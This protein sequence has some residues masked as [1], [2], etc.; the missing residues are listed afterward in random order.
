RYL[1][2]LQFKS[3]SEQEQVFDTTVASPDGEVLFK[4]TDVVFR[5]V[6][7]EQIK[8]AMES[9]MAEDDQKMYEAARHTEHRAS[10]QC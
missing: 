7:P 3:F 9:Q 5:K 1:C 8:K 10:N 2:H 6:L 4:G